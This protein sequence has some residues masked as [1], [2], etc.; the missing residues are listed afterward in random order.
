MAQLFRAGKTANTGT[1]WVIAVLAT[2]MVFCGT[3]AF[4]DSYAAVVPPPQANVITH[5]TPLG[6]DV[7][8]GVFRSSPSG[9]DVGLILWRI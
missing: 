2:A 4:L 3:R 9:E 7:H 1:R 5:S 6:G 8:D